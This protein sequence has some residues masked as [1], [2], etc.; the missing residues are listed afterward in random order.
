[1]RILIT[2]DDGIEGEGIRLLANWAKN[3]GDVLVVAPKEQ[4]SACSHSIILR[5]AFE[6]AKSCIFSDIGIDAYTVDATPADCVRF[7]VEKFGKFDLVFSGINHGMNVGHDISYSG[8]CGAAFEANF[9][10]LPSVAFSADIGCL[11]VAAKELDTIWEFFLNND[12]LGRAM[13]YN[14]NVPAAPKGIRLTAQG[15][16][17]YRD[18]FIDCGNNTYKANLYMAKDADEPLDENIDT[19]AIMLGYCSITPL[20]VNRTDKDALNL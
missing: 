14:V 9:A 18:H 12:L 13:M 11:D 17:F 2:N 16:A 5:R 7:S 3:I 6:V 4:Q 1:M 15:G 10:S 8:T 19:D 20:T